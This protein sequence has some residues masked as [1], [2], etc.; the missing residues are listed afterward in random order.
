MQ[1]SSERPYRLIQSLG[2]LGQ[3]PSGQ[4]PA[5]WNSEE[6]AT[7]PQEGVRVI[8]HDRGEMNRILESLESHIPE[9]PEHYLVPMLIGED[10]K[11]VFG[12]PE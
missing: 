9:I 11:R 10:R 4:I 5:S 7:M 12:C 8:R 2:S 6:A 1:F 3:V